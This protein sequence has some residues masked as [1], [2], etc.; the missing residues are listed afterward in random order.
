MQILKPCH[1]NC[2]V[3]ERNAQLKVDQRNELYDLLVYLKE[4]NDTE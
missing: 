3:Q 2:E 1:V 4:P